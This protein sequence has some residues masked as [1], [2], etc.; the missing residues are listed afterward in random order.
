MLIL[1]T[2]VSG[3]GKS[4]YAEKI[5]CDLADGEKK[6]YIAT[7]Q[8]FGAEG[9]ER[10]RRHH[11]LR[12]GKGFDT[13][14]QYQHVNKAF[15]NKKFY[16]GKDGS[17]ISAGNPDQEIYE[18]VEKKPVVLLECLSNLMANECF[19]KGGT[20]DAVFSDCMQLYSQCRHLVI[21]TNEIF[22]DGCLYE[23]TTTDYIARLGRLNTQLAQE[24][25]YVAEV[26]YSIP[27][28]LKGIKEEW[29]R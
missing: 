26:V 13:I 18:S 27:V 28:Y 9:Q 21:V 23:N 19:E 10:I 15:M 1:V 4:E 16:D 25:D 17:G 29:Q 22:S 7:M 24:A 8:P 6:Y 20:P 3:S 5:C 2:G 12:Q 14:E 11:A